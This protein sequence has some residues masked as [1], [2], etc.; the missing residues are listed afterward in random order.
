MGYQLYEAVGQIKTLEQMAPDDHLNPVISMKEVAK[1]II[2]KYEDSEID[3]IWCCYD[4]YAQG[5]YQALTELG[6]EIPMVSVDICDE[7][8]QYMSEGKNWKACATTNWTLN[9]EFACR[10]LALEMAEQYDAIQA[11]SCYYENLGMWMEIPSVVITQEQILSKENIT[12]QNLS[13]VAEDAYTDKSW[14]PTCDWMTTALG[15]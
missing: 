8:I 2:G 1:K 4:T 15:N 14:M 9:G 3:A 6:S 11:A 13:D 5:V 10:V 12:I 7:D